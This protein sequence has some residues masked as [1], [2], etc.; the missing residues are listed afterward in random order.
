MRRSSYWLRMFRPAT[1]LVAGSFVSTGLARPDLA[2]EKRISRGLAWSPS[3]WQR[4]HAEGPQGFKW[5]KLEGDEA[6]RPG[7]NA[8][9]LAGETP[10]ATRI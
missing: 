4:R 5:E 2:L 1:F 8:P 7:R 9:E 10:N 6:V 3:A